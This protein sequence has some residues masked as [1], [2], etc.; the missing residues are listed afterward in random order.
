MYRKM[1]GC[2]LCVWLLM[3]AWSGIS[4]GYAQSIDNL[5]LMTEN[6]PPFNFE[7]DGK[8]QGI[9][10]DAM[11]RILEKLGAKQGRQNIAL[12]PWARGYKYLQDQPNTCLFAM[13]RS[14]EREPLFKWVG[15]VMHSKMVL[16]ARK[17]RRLSIKSL[18]ELKK[19]R[20]GVVIDDIGELLLVDAGMTNLERMSGVNAAASIIKMLNINRLDLWSYEESVAKWLIKEMGMN[21]D[22]YATVYLL[23][24]TAD[25][26]AFHKDTPDALIQ[27]M[28]AALDE[29]VQQGEFAKIV[30]SYLQ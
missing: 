30:N 4:N 15:P 21:S 23:E 16:I 11:V 19:Y 13:T 26:F 24:E 17:D 9:F 28:Q 20:I 12:L 2:L 10:I 1:C 18:E 29:L 5:K 14:P 6:Y 3:G 25:Y 27:Q 8:L 7:K 22:D